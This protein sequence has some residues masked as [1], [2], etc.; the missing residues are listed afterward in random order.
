M[1]LTLKNGVLTGCIE[2]ALPSM[3]NGRRI[4][5]AGRFGRPLS[6][7]SDACTAFIQRMRDAYW[8][9]VSE[10]AL[11]P[12]QVPMRGPLAFEMTLFVRNGR[13]DLGR[14]LL[15]DTLQVLGLIEDDNQFKD[16][17]NRIYLDP[18]RPRVEFEVRG[19]QGAGREG[20]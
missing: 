19:I 4:V 2:G 3:K 13:Q 18:K 6:I 12:S 15:W 1:S 16:E 7:K 17:R 14:D 5:R 11:E 10:V 8:V 20:R 9:A